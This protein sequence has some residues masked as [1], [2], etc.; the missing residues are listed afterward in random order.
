MGWLARNLDDLRCLVQKLT[1]CR[2]RIEFVKESL[3]CTDEDSP[4]ANLMLSV[5]GA[6]AEFERALIRERQREDIINTRELDSYALSFHL[7]RRLAGKAADVAG[8]QGRP[9]PALHI[10]RYRLIHHPVTMLPSHLLPVLSRRH[11]WG[12]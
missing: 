2:V 10:Q 11:P 9:D 12:R 7:V 1:K 6:F 8:H 4:M 3:T 5:I